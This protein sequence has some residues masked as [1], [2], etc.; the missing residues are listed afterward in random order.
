M[1]LHPA[2]SRIRKLSAEIPAEFVVFD[3]LLWDGEPV[4]KLPLEERRARVEALAGFRLSPATRD[5]AEARGWLDRFEALGLDGVIAQAARPA[6]SARLARGRRQGE[7]AQ[8]GRLRR[9]RRALEG[10]D[11]PRDRDA[12]ARALPR[13]RRHSTTSAR[14]PSRPGKREEVADRVLPLLDEPSGQ[15]LLGAEPLGH[16][17]ARGESR[18]AGARRRGALRQGAGQPLPPRHEASSAGATTRIRA[19]ARGASSARR[20]TRTP[21]GAESAEPELTRYCRVRRLRSTKR[22]SATAA[23][24]SAATCRASDRRPPRS[25]RAS[26]RS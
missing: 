17:R 6:V 3:V 1:R 8:D 21:P 9:R 16:G 14:A 15:R 24:A 22:R 11:R 23:T 4:W 7:G 25:A 2:E 13:R 5:L 12:A 20:A 10:D 19:T 18:C 26:S